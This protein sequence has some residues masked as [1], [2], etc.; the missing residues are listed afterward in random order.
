MKIAL[1]GATGGTGRALLA[2]ALERGDEVRALARNPSSLAV[3]DRNLT[4]IE[5]DVLDPA[6]VADCLADTDAVACILGTKPGQDP[7]ESRGTAVIVGQ[8]QHA[9]PRRLVVV[10][11]MGVGDSLDQVALPFRLVM[12]M[13]LKR[14]MEDKERQE[15]LV[16]Q[17]GLDWTIVRPGGLTD[18]PRTGRYQAGVEKT[19]RAGRV[20]RPDVADFILSLLGDDRFLHQTPAIS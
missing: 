10:T 17:S 9:G 18:G 6:A 12:Q 15:Q 16:M 4:I 3:R 11:S 5:G 20:A 19:I 8:M 2:Q 13:T 7:I 1:F 14:I